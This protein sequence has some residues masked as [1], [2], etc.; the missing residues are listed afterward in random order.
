MPDTPIDLAVYG[1]LKATTGSE[2]VAELVDTYIEEAQGMLADLRG[3]REAG[4]ADRFRRAAHSLKS[5]AGTF[6]AMSVAAI[7][8]ELELNG[9]DADPARDRD[10]LLALEAAHEVATAALKALRHG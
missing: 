6:G 2:F 4:D 1:E 8:R 9:L 10:K 7:A 3:A 5:N